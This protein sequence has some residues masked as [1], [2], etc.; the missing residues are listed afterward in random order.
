MANSTDIWVI[1]ICGGLGE[2]LGIFHLVMATLPDGLKHTG[3]LGSTM[4]DDIDCG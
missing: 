4:A 1:K 3:R 2:D